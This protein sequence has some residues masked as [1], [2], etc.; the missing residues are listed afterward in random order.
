M[1]S[2]M[3]TKPAVF[4]VGSDYQIMVPVSCQT[5]MW[6]KVGDENY[7]D[8]SNGIIR[9]AVTTHRMT[10][11]AEEL[12]KAR[13]YT[14]CWRK[15]I[16][17]KPYFSET[18]EVESQEFEFFPVEGDGVT[19][20]HIADAHNSVDAPVEAALQ[21]KEKIGR[22]DFLIMNGDI[23]DH[24]GDISNFD[25]IYEIAAQITNGN[26]PVIFSRG[27]HDTRG[28]FAE[29][30][31]EHTPCENGNSYY[32]FRLG[33]IWG[34]VMDSGEDKHDTNPEYGNTVCCHQFRKRETKYLERVINHSAEEYKADGI[35][36]KLVIV[37]TPF[38][39][40]HQPPFDIEHEIYNKWA[41]LLE[42]NVQP[43]VM[44]CGHEHD[45]GIFEPGYC[46]KT[47]AGK[48]ISDLH[49]QPCPLVLGSLPKGIYS[50]DEEN[51]YAGAGFIFNANNIDVMFI[52]NKGENL[53][54]G[55]I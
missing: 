4:A 2:V 17:R 55:V 51:Y 44:I 35:K 5:L 20:F 23:P 29:N 6:V 49:R 36:H 12:N 45:I 33:N 14:V 37:H 42:D 1:D 3:K 46:D 8:D 15:I 26:I 16:E 43:D 52:D 11:P 30:I 10:V 34:I 53:G 48:K 24:S 31:A 25:N 22:L 38:T 21:F 50:E 7:Y 54:G 28:I 40:K 13:K 9:S 41:R 32:T 18:G 19:A 27:N 47:V 39:W